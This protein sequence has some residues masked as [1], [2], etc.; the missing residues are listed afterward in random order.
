MKKNDGK[1]LEQLVELIEKS[2]ARSTDHTAKVER[3]VNL[4]VL[5]SSIGA[6][7]Q[8]DII[9]RSGV[10]PRET[11]TIVEVQD[12]K[13]AVEIGH[14]S[15]WITKLDSVG[16]QQLICVSRHA[17]PESIK[18]QVALSGTKVRLTI[19]ANFY[20]DVVGNNYAKL[21]EF[22]PKSEPIIVFS[23]IEF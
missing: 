11:I 15:D 20:Q 3:N 12:R 2:I 19:S 7:R 8:C 4:P 23:N 9:I 21:I 17:F 5:N 18:E 13:E 1:Y 10:V 14:Y 22:S 16:A 6:T